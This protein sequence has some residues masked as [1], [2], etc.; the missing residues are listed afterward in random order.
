MHE[1]RITFGESVGNDIL[2]V[3]KE[4]ASALFGGYTVLQAEGGWVDEKGNLITENSRVLVIRANDLEDLEVG[5][6]TMTVNEW[7]QATAKTLKRHSDED[8]I[9]WDIREVHTG[10]MV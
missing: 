2:T 6:R 1:I 4:K 8:A 5:S 10:G 3:V 7:T 9:M